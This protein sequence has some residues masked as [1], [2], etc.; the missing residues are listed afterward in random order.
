MWPVTV[1]PLILCTTVHSSLVYDSATWFLENCPDSGEQLD[2]YKLTSLLRTRFPGSSSFSVEK[3]SKEWRRIVTIYYFKIYK[4]QTGSY[5]TAITIE[6]GAKWYW[7]KKNLKSER[8]I[9]KTYLLLQLWRMGF[10]HRWFRK[11][12]EKTNYT[13]RQTF[14]DVPENFANGFDKL[15]SAVPRWGH[16]IFVYK[17]FLDFTR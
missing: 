15:R 9:S 16:Y 13:E 12:L 17:K 3:L 1:P 2:I 4:L 14:P 5:S 11:I 10:A 8:T 7:W 6:I